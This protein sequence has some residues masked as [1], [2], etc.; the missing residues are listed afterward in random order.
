M[1][2]TLGV[3][4]ILVSREAAEHRLTQHADQCMAA[5]LAGTRVSQC[6]SSRCAQTERVI[7][8]AIGE[9]TGIGGHD[10]SAK[11]HR[12]TAVEIKSKNA[13]FGFTRQ[14]RHFCLT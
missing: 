8:F 3:V 9:Q 2:Q 11:L 14:V 5:V 4:H 10:G 7:E 13:V 12:D 1:A 6:F